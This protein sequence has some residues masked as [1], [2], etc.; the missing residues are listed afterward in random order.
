MFAEERQRTI[1]KM[2]KEN[3]AVRTSEL[4]TKFSTS[5]ETVRR[6]LLEMEKKRLL[7]R[8]HGGA[9]ALPEMMKQTNLDFRTHSNYNE[10]AELSKTALSVINNG[11]AV[12]ID[13]GS[14]VICLAEAIA[15]K[16]ER[17]TVVT[18]S[19]DVFNILNA[20]GKFDLIVTG[21]LFSPEENAFTGALA[22]GALSGIH[23]QK[24]FIAPAAVSLGSG[25]FD[26]GHEFMLIQKKVLEVS[27]EIFVLADSEKFEKTALYKLS[28]T[29][30][31]YTYI[32]DSSLSDNVKAIYREN[33]ITILN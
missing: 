17:L 20:A 16:L 29:R 10:K 26:Y 21:G 23:I 2:L 25:I 5:S 33:G 22:L 6:D 3:G 1:L 30:P 14:T 24:A 7:Q 28:D 12:F 9:L 4:L 11:D 19:M 8:V 15:E 32:T 18:N 27:N 31:E 13:C